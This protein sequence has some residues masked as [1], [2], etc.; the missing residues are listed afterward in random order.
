MSFSYH[1]ICVFAHVN[2]FYKSSENCSSFGPW[3]SVHASNLKI[4]SLLKQT[5]EKSAMNLTGK[6]IITI[7]NYVKPHTWSLDRFQLK[8]Y[9]FIYFKSKAEVNLI[10]VSWVKSF[11]KAIVW[12]TSFIHNAFHFIASLLVDNFHYWIIQKYI[13]QC[14]VNNSSICELGQEYCPKLNDMLSITKYNSD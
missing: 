11:E 1:F 7:R 12:I 5:K 10:W 13:S 8:T 9:L 4:K 2:T 14:P 3:K 6:H